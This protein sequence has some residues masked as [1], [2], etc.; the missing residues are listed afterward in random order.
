M[1]RV[2]LTKQVCDTT[3]YPTDKKG[4]G[5]YALQDT[6]V[7]GLALRISSENRKRWVLRYRFGGR[8]REMRLGPYEALSVDHARKLSREHLGSV[9][10]GVDP[11]RDKDRIKHEHTFEQLCVDYLEKK[12]VHLRTSSEHERRVNKNL[13]PMLG[14]KPVS[15]VTKA[16]IRKI[17][18]GMKGSPYE[19]N[20]TLM[21]VSSIYKFAVGAGY[22]DEQTPHW[23]R[24]IT[25][26]PEKKRQRWLHGEELQ[27]FLEALAKEPNPVLR[28]AILFLL[29][30]GLRKSEALG[31]TWD[32]IDFTNGVA[33]IPQ[34]KNNEPFTVPLSPQALQILREMQSIACNEWCF[35]SLRRP[36][37]PVSEP[38][39]ALRRACERAGITNVRLHDLRRSFGSNAVSAG[40]PLEVVSHLLNHKS[41]HTTRSVYGHLSIDPLKKA[42]EKIGNVLSFEEIKERE[43]ESA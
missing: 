12:A 36:G 4:K 20:R 22:I 25:K 13:L 5:F 27:R 39:F 6:E 29:H 11:Q 28:G 8:T 40:L 30:T 2:R 42:T 24:G 38:Q 3:E 7:H 16:D 15:M 10:T 14:K 34:T 23:A 19:A 1:P 32:R 37:I 33:K 17:H 31:L 43:E 41:I 18:E 35:P 21:L 9:A 26:Y